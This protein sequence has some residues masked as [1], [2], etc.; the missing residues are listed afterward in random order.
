VFV[1]VTIAYVIL[2][3]TGKAGDARFRTPLVPL[4]ALL[5]ALGIRYCVQRV[6]RVAAAPP[7]VRQEDP[8]GAG[9]GLAS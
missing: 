4:I 2:I 7:A 1:I 9:S 6:R 3:S 8:V 5:A